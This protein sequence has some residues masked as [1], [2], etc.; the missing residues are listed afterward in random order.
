MSLEPPEA[1]CQ[2]TGLTG[3]PET[4]TRGNHVLAHKARRLKRGGDGQRKAAKSR[5]RG[6]AGNV[7]RLAIRCWLGGKTCKACGAG[8]C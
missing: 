8:S 1:A 2:T 6:Y 5:A 4:R 7:A 3:Q